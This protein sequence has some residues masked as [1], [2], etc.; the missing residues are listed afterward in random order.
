MRDAESEEEFSI[1]GDAPDQGDVWLIPLKMLDDD[2][3]AIQLGAVAELAVEAQQR[4]FVGDPLRMMLISLEEESRFPYVIE[5]GGAAVGVLTLQTGAA[6]LA[7]WPDDVSVWLLRGFLIDSKSQGRGLGTLAAR[8]AVEEARRLTV[9]L[10][11]GQAGV[12]LSAN[13][14][15][16]AA[17]S[18]YSK[19]GFVDS[20]RYMG[21]SAGPQRTMYKA[22]G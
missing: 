13:E 8:A 16:P 19:A 15:N 7:G 18:A 22:F 9:R 17:L 6:T 12:V 14:R 5:S 11:G 10:G 3:R 2:A 1:H 20:G 21:G 4:D